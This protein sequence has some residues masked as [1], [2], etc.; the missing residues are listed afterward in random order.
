MCRVVN[1]DIKNA[2]KKRKLLDLIY[3]SAG[4]VLGAPEYRK[5]LSKAKDKEMTNK[6]TEIMDLDA[7]R[8]EFVHLLTMQVNFRAKMPHYVIIFGQ[9]FNQAVKYSRGTLL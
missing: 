1:S 6:I 5:T 7:F 3:F 8:K 4:N 2:A 9:D